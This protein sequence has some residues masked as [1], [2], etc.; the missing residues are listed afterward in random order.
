[1]DDSQIIPPPPAGGLGPNSAPSGKPAGI[2]YRQL[3][4]PV[5]PIAPW[6][7][8][9]DGEHVGAEAQELGRVFSEF[10]NASSSVADHFATVAGQQ[11]GAKAGA[12]GN[13]APKSGLASIT[14]FGQAYDAAVHQTYITHSQLALENQLS[15]IE[16]N[17]TGDPLSFQKQAG[18]AVASALKQMP[19]LYQPEMTLWAQ[20]RIQAGVNRQ[21]DQALSDA[22]NTA[23]ATYQQSTPDLITS[24][25]HTAAALPK[26]Q[27]DG[28]IAK[29]VSDD[30]DRLNA[31]V[32]SHVITPEQAVTMHQK[33]IDST[34]AQLT[35]QK[36]D[37]SLQP[38]LQ[39]MRSNVEAA[40]KLIV[41]NDPNLTPE[42]NTARVQEYEKEREAYEQQQTHAYADQLGQV[43]QQLAGGSY[44]QGVESTLHQL[45][46]AGALSQEGLYSGLAESIRNQK[47]RIGDEADMQLV[48][49]IVHG[50]PGHSGPLD[51][52]NKAEAAA[53][54]KYF[55]EHIGQSGAVSGDQYA[56]GA[57]EIVR[58]TGIVPASVE[59]QIR[60]G[61]LS[62]DPVRT[63]NAAA[64]AA[65]IT[66]VNPNVDVFNKSPRLAALAHLVSDNL[67]AGM[68]A[69]QAYALARSIRD[70]P[71]EQRKIR[72]A[73]YGQALKA[74]GPNADYLQKQLGHE[75][76]GFLGFSHSLPVPVAMQ[77]QFDG[78]T[79]EYYDETGNLQSAR[80]LAAKQL[81]QQWGPSKVNGSVELMKYPIPDNMVPVVRSDIATDAKAAGYNGDPSSIHLVPNSYTDA[82]GGKVWGLVHTDPKTG[83]SDVL[84]DK[85]NRPLVYKLPSGPD[86]IAARQR[87][88]DE[89]LAQ[90]RQER[91]DWRANSAE[92]ITYEKQLSDE[93]LS[94]NPAQRAMAGR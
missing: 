33:M 48:D 74:Q 82:S 94:G 31:L 72:D 45:Y 38:I 60:I 77:A 79:R 65:R 36:I 70:I 93:M 52:Q 15:T 10:E 20:A 78:L 51:P 46:Q 66:G 61:L 73:T 6:A 83:L 89:K 16:S 64:L 12:A 44:G 29:L 21:R 71:P 41:Q 90:A 76:S 69:Q 39:T 3:Q 4:R 28:V 40:D 53:V 37:L 84:L 59:S 63:A 26:E 67:A 57:A 68:P 80:D 81:G 9:R 75:A 35:G 62:G 2:D 91:A 58:Q 7:L 13:G 49:A 34:H 56:A 27:G 23:L 18:T 30:Q 86:F 19:P 5:E 50:D 32:A 17:S 24:A 43:H 88:I 92:Q 55:Q 85:N 11:A 8:G 14:A 22:R 87:L 1:M 25:L 47:K 42:E 54:D